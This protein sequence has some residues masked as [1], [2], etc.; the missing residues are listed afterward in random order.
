MKVIHN[1]TPKEHYKTP[2]S[3]QQEQPITELFI[4][5]RMMEMHESMKLVG[6]AGDSFCSS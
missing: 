3:N 2:S 5:L 6:V 4:F 1:T